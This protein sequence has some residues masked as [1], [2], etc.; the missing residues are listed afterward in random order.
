MEKTSSLILASASPRRAQILRDADIAFEIIAPRIEE[1]VL[2]GEPAEAMVLRLAEAKARAAA[3]SLPA[4]MRRIFVLGADTTVLAGTDGATILGKPTSPEDAARM[5]R[6]LSGRTHRVLTG[7][8]VVRLPDGEFRGAVESTLVTFAEFGESEI[9]RAIA[10]GEPFDKAGAYAIQGRA[11]RF[12]ERVEGCY[13]NVVGLP[14]HRA[15]AL[16]GEL[17]WSANSAPPA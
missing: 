17:G 1:T 12:V 7:I 10:S 8:A 3:G 11:G 2:P 16:L 14:L 5:L 4:A 9:A 15:C 6:L 13:F